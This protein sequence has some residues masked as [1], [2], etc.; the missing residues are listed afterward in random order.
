MKFEMYKDIDKEWRWRLVAR[1]GRIIADS[2]E[3]C[4]KR[5]TM[6]KTMRKL[7]KD[8]PKVDTD[9]LAQ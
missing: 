1:N 9:M 8:L 6:K 5:A 2:A 4:K 7:V 3:G